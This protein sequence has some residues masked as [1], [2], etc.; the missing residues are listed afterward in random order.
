MTSGQVDDNDVLLAALRGL[1]TEATR[2]YQV[3]LASGDVST[4]TFHDEPDVRLTGSAGAG[5]PMSFHVDADDQVTVGVGQY[6][7]FEYTGDGGELLDRIRELV[8]AVVQGEV[9]EDVKV[10][11]SGRIRFKVVIRRKGAPD[12]RSSGSTFVGRDSPVI[13]RREYEP[14]AVRTPPG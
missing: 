6:G 14:Y 8:L 10:T 2:G 11:W 9:I 5:A 4:D 7:R 13:G 1:L 3:D 12:L